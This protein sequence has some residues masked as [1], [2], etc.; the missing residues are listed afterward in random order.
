MV[1]DSF[2][3]EN[4]KSVAIDAREEAGGPVVRAMM[5][6]ASLGGVEAA[7][8]AAIGHDRDGDKVL[9]LLGETPVDVSNIQRVGG[10][11]TRRCHAWLSQAIG[12]RTVVYMNEG[13]HLSL[14][15]SDLVELVRSS[16]I[17]HLDGRESD[18]AD[19]AIEAARSGGG[20]VSLD[21]GSQK[22]GLVE[23][24]RRVDLV[25]LPKSTMQEI[26]S[27]KSINDSAKHLISA[28]DS[29]NSVIVTDGNHGCFG[30]ND[31]GEELFVP[32]F[33][34][35]VVDSNGAGD[36]FAGGVV[37]AMAKK[38]S[39]LECMRVGSAC[40]AIKCRRLGNANM[41]TP[42][43]IRGLIAEDG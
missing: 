36:V 30:Y 43:D 18:T 13:P 12:S 2:P 37:W 27:R 29:L 42:D 24:I 23:L 8:V 32:A 35:E 4:T 25:I 11:R 34:V 39:L 20:T 1:V 40:A 41:P 9:E 17:L 3:K 5:T 7:V 31:S 10:Q 26:G 38:K 28:S 21:A 19:A 33:S 22:S 14:L 16:S 6:V 15:N